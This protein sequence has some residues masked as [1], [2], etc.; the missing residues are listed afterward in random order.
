MLRRCA[1][2]RSVLES[3]NYFSSTSV[4]GLKIDSRHDSDDHDKD[5]FA[6]LRTCFTCV[7]LL[8][9]AGQSLVCRCY[10]L[11]LAA[12][13][14]DRSVQCFHKPRR[15]YSIFR[16]DSRPDGSHIPRNSLQQYEDNAPRPE[17]TGGAMWV[18]SCCGGELLVRIP[19]MGYLH[20]PTG[21]R[22]NL[23]R[24]TWC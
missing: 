4:E 13:S 16:I 14:G 23:E 2:S 24:S 12:E 6:L 19:G 8:R 17:C 15:I 18:E 20:L 11:E 22:S 1:I 10:I 3:S 21:H 5:R 7:A 9:I